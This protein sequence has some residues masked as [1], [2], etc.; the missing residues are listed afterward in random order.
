MFCTLRCISQGLGSKQQALLP[1][2]VCLTLD[3]GRNVVDT[4]ALSGRLQVYISRLLEYS[5]TPLNVTV[6]IV[7]K[8]KCS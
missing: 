1:I 3:N 2:D 6:H 5:G 8:V 4:R 7:C